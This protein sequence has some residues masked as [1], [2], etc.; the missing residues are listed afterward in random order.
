[1]EAA[2]R[3]SNREY[4][5]TSKLWSYSTLMCRNFT[6]VENFDTEGIRYRMDP[7][8]GGIVGGVP[9]NLWTAPI[10]GRE[11]LERIIRLKQNHRFTTT[12]YQD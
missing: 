10:N 11:S 12:D 5:T 4:G 1:M 8:L 2:T 6:T 9:R 3:W 7:S